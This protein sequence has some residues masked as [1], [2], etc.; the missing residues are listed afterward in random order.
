[1]SR[2]QAIESGFGAFVD[3]VERPESQTCYQP[4][5][6]A[7]EDF[8]YGGSAQIQPDDCE[9]SEQA[10]RGRTYLG[11]V[12]CRGAGGDTLWVRFERTSA[13]S[14][15]ETRQETRVDARPPNAAPFA[16]TLRSTSVLR[17]TGDCTQAE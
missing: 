14:I 6:R 9:I 5:L 17:R 15:V 11:T 13:A 3:L 10:R 1:M 8:G 4:S 12:S 7:E 2:E 16:I